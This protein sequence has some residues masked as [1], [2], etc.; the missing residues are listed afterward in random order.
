MFGFLLL[1][2]AAVIIG[3]VIAY[4][5]LRRLEDERHRVRR[6]RP[7]VP[8][9]EKHPPVDLTSMAAAD[10]ARR[11]QPQ[12]VDS[13][14][15]KDDLKRIAGIGPKLEQTLNANGIYSY[16]QIADW[17]EADIAAFDELLPAFHGRIRRDDWVGQA[18]QLADRP[19]PGDH[20]GACGS[21][22]H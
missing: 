22:G 9:P 1:V 15:A 18:R 19:G 13:S 17:D 10:L 16:R 4:V 21:E 20:F 11:Q 3:L 5:Y 12:A 7:V 14:P 8:L 2:I 6:E